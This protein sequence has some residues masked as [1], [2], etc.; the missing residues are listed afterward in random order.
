V[1][2]VLYVSIRMSNP[3]R[4]KV[5]LCVRSIPRRSNPR[6]WLTLNKIRDVS[7]FLVTEL[8]SQ[9]LKGRIPQSTLASND[10]TRD[11]Q[12]FVIANAG[13]PEESV[14]LTYGQGKALLAGSRHTRQPFSAFR[15]DVV[16]RILILSTCCPT[17]SAEAQVAAQRHYFGEP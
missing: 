16:G 3:V 12:N 8:C 4:F 15:D 14:A 2:T 10:F 5:R 11:W 7:T 17:S 13:R 9:G 1:P 6:S